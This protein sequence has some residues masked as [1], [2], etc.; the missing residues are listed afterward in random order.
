MNAQLIFNRI[1]IIHKT[2]IRNLNRM[3]ERKEENLLKPILC[4]FYYDLRWKQTERMTR[5]IEREIMFTWKNDELCSKSEY[6][7]L[8]THWMNRT[9]KVNADSND[10]TIF[11]IQTFQ[12]LSL[13]ILFLS[14]SCTDSIGSFFPFFALI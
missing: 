5:K 3:K 11:S 7:Q 9:F 12:I 2:K 4:S 13:S 1:Y 10:F 14:I 8:I 6:T